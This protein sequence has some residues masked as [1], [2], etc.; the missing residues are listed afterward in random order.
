MM[1]KKTVVS[2]SIFLLAVFLPA[3]PASADSI[4]LVLSNPA[5]TAAP[6]STL[7]FDATVSAPLANSATVFLNA[8]NFGDNIPGSTIDDSGFLLNFPLSLDPGGTFTGTLFSVALPSNV[9]PG[10][11]TGFFEIF[12]GSSPDAAGPLATVNFQIAATPEPGTWV[13][14][15]TG[16]GILA[17][18]MT[19]RRHRSQVSA[20][21]L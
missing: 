7:I 5:Q 14:L 1:M 12:G 13:L 10:S 3:A 19:G 20:G 15:A 8:D 17:M 16:L 2:L 4:T 9:V 18:G 6:G 21:S 11:Y